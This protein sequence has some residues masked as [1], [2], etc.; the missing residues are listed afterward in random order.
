MLMCA[1]PGSPEV[2]IVIYFAM[3]KNL[4]VKQKTKIRK[5]QIRFTACF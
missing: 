1:F 4:W 5:I 3:L 2:L